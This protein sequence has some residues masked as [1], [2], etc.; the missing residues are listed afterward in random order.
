MEQTI[1]I[2]ITHGDIN[3]SGYEM[4]L[5]A[6][7]DPTMFELCTPIV[8]GSAQAAAFYA[9]RLQQ[10]GIPQFYHI[11]TAAEAKQ[12]RLNLIDC[13]EN[14][15]IEIHPGESTPESGK[16]AMV[17]LQA[18]VE[19]YKKGAFDVLVTCPVTRSSIDGFHGHADYLERQLNEAGKGLS[20]LMNEDLRVALVTNNLAVKDVSESITK[21]KI[22]EKGL[23]FAQTLKRDL[24][25]SSP[26]IAVL[27]LNPRCGEDGA[28]GDEEQEIILPAIN[29]LEEK[30]VQAFGPY[31]ADNFF[32]EGQYYRFDG[33]LAMYHDQG[34]TPFKTLS[35][36][37]GVRFTGGLSIVRTAPA[38]PTTLRH[39]IWAATDVLNNRKEYDAPM[40]NPLPKLY[41]ERRDESEKVRFR[42]PVANSQPT[43]QE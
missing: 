22:V 31:A 6:F 15:E 29:E 39:A 33:V 7:N 23:L 28:L 1:R 37:N 26:R 2:A 40:G 36:N 18:A 16:A 43:E 20:I 3:G 11:K 41:H 19:D 12:N 9:S 5:K 8:Y 14:A 24:R 32:G 38:Y 25:V 30:G 10:E 27:S 17:A 35:P 21:Q 34:M 4:I 42:A 13:F